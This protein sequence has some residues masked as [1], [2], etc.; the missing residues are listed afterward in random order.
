MSSR[1]LERRFESSC[2][3]WWNGRVRIFMKSTQRALSTMRDT[4]SENKQTHQVPR[5]S[6][7]I[8]PSEGDPYNL[9]R[10]V[11]AQEGEYDRAVTELRSGKK[12]TH[13]MWF[14]FP[15]IEGLG[16][17]L[18]SFRYAIKGEGEARAYLSHPILGARLRE[19]AQIVVNT[20]GRTAHEIFGSPDD[21]KLR[22]CATL[23]A[24]VSEDPVFQNVLDK[25]FDARP[26]ERTLLL[27]E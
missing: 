20:E 27:L 6:E 5:V 18:L 11:R 1:R 8:H 24:R 21:M 19:C 13:W 9:E 7:T 25:F 12:Y 10:F 23:F 26:D 14:V 2:E 4:G 16:H 17:S 3:D 15:Q 22:S